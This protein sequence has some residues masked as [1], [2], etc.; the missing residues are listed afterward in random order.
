[1]NR[2]PRRAAGGQICDQGRAEFG[3]PATTVL[4]QIQRDLAKAIE[5]GAVYDRAA[6]SFAG[7]E[8]GPRQDRQMRRHGVLRNIEP[9]CKL[10]GSDTVR[11]P[12]DQQPKRVEPCR[13]GERGKSS[14]GGRL[15]HKS[16]IIDLIESH[17]PHLTLDWTNS[18]RQSG[19]DSGS[20]NGARVNSTA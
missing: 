8:T 11:L 6:M 16:S 17:N 12:S 3:P 14:Y 19:E 10:A 20:R 2:L 18:A 15:I 5:V 13:L 1:M 9:P 4:E 7:D